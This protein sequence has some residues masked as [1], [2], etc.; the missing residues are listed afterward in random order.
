MTE[1][2]IT[3]YPLGNADTTLI[4]PTSGK[5]ILFDYANM[6][7]PNNQFDKRINLPKE[8]NKSVKGDYDVV[9][10]THADEDHTK[11][12][13]EYFHLWHAEK[14]QK[15]DRKKI[16][17]LWVP[18]AVVLET[19]LDGDEVRILR[20][21]ARYRLTV[22]KSGIKVFSKPEKLKEWYESTSDDANFDD[23]KH[24]IVNAGQLV[25]G[26][27]KANQGVEFFIHSPFSEKIDESTNIDRNN[28]G[29][30]VQ[31]TFGNSANSKVILGADAN[32][33]LWEDIISVTKHYGRGEYLEWDIFHISHHCSYT[34]LS[35]EKSKTETTP[36]DE[37][38][39]LYETQGN[40]RAYLVSPSK[41]IPTE[42][43][44]Q[45][46]HRQ[47]AKYYQKV[48]DKLQGRFKVTMDHPTKHS[49][50]PMVFKIHDNFGIELL[51]SGTTSGSNQKYGETPP[52]AGSDG[53]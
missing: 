37:I 21:E 9:C 47:A 14:Y 20:Q 41:P 45:P 32:Y 18:A 5:K 27:D 8:L 50:K 53:A 3:F 34:A 12:F 26:F 40:T 15:G 24:L 38:K 16:K 43:T 30:I 49:P 4:E 48:A 51:L 46:P 17:D 35:A 28:S 29:I 33:E 31:A 1:S 2:K 11:G 19:N 23:I 7:A 6:R 36:T 52:R 22:L 42:D 44:T 39:W 13:S 10:F 25:P